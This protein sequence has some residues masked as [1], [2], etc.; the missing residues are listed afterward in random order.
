VDT[1]TDYGHNGR[2]SDFDFQHRQIVFFFTPFRPVSDSNKLFSSR[3]KEMLPGVKQVER[4][5]DNLFATPD[6][7]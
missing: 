5:A 2:K 7:G 6:K 1:T 3:Y 4:E